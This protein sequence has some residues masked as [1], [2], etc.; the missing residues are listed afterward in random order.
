MDPHAAWE[1]MVLPNWGRHGD[2]RMKELTAKQFAAIS[3]VSV[4]TLRHHD[5]IGL[6]RPASVGANGYCKEI[7]KLSCQFCWQVAIPVLGYP[8]YCF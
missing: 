2:S 6:L 7:E 4:R 5:E 1:S 8:R 3:S